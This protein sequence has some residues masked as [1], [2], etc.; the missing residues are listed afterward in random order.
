MSRT[1]LL[2]SSVV[3]AVMFCLAMVLST[4]SYTQELS[5]LSRLDVPTT[6]SLTA[7]AKPNIVFILT[8]DMRKDDLK[9]MPKT[10]N[11]LRGRGKFFENAFV[12]N[13]ICCPSRA[14][15]MRGQYTH[16]THVWENTNSS[17]GAG[18]R[19]GPGATNK[20]T[21]PR[22]S[23]PLATGRRSSAST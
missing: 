2:V 4:E 23:T 9:Y 16:N 3:P 11:L 5:L 15:I 22:A 10:R 12:S 19:T 21:W 6:E 20:T 13:P 1:F 7:P 14:T 8:D 18:K 17:T